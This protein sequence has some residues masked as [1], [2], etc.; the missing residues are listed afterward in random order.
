[1]ESDRLN[2]SVFR[3]FFSER[4]V[5]HEERRLRTESTPTGTFQEQFDSMF[6]ISSGYSWPVIGWTS[7][8]NSY[9]MEEALRYWDT[10]YRPNNLV[11]IVV[12][13]FR[14][15]EIKPVIER[16]FSRLKPGS[17]PPPPVV[18]LEH[19]PVAEM[20]MNAEAEAQPSV[21]MRYHT[22]P[23]RHRDSY[24]LDVLASILNSRTGRLYK[25]MVEGKSIAS[26]ARAGQD[27]RKY[28]GAF[29]I[30][31]ETKGEATPAQLEAALDEEIARLQ[32]DL[33]SPEELQKVK[34]QA[35][36]DQYRRLQSNFFLL[37]QLAMNEAMGGWEEIN[38][39]G[40]KIQ[41]VT[42]EDIRRVAQT[43]LQRNNRAVATYVRKQGSAAPAD[44]AELAALPAPAQA[45]V[46]QTLQ[47]IA[48]ETDLAKLKGALARMEEQASGGEVP[49]EMRPVLEYLK[50]RFEE[51]VAEL[52]KAA[53]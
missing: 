32:K 37:I 39:E 38:D 45:M 28:A 13:D 22:V 16:Y 7:D 15:A 2:D 50:K 3:E 53:K 49:A 47:R 11:G 6:W 51:R 34:N 26:S 19:K 42:A 29:S 48:K 23:F 4:D 9:T 31:A 25:S 20:R 44:D 40:A 46:K 41:A 10:F 21:E 1:M 36:A 14:P 52:E 18:T 30:G 8:L 27:S 5:V 43:Y 12:G 33:V 17:S 24:P 35:A